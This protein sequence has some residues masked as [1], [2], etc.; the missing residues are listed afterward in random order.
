L[1][2]RDKF[3][4]LTF[5][6]KWEKRDESAAPSRPLPI[7]LPLSIHRAADSFAI[8]DA[9]GRIVAAIP[10]EGDASRERQERRFSENETREMAQLIAGL[11]TDMD[12][13]RSGPTT[14]P[15]EALSAE[16]DE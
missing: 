14:I 7:A 12:A 13:G 1:A 4:R 6:R 3:G 11:L 8:L 9:A 15:L 10:F 2:H 5:G 16:N